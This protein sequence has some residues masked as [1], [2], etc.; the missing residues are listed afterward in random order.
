VIPATKGEQLLGVLVFITDVSADEQIRVQ[1]Q[2]LEHR[3]VLGE[4]TAIFAHE[5]R[6][7][8][9]NISSGLQLLAS[10]NEDD[11]F[12]Q[13]AINRMQSDCGRLD[14]LMESVLAFS[15]PFE[16]VLEASEYR[17]TAAKDPQPL[18]PAPG[19]SEC[20]RSLSRGGRYARCFGGCPLAGAGI[21]EFDQ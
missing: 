4:F 13:D 1:T 5:V 11:A 18:A 6:N 16:S 3:A 19:Q 14:H 9:N 21:Y 7:P 10:M 15:R 2:Q 8:I 17:C 12:F 20:E